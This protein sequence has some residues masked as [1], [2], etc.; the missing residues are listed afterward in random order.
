MVNPQGIEV[1]VIRSIAEEGGHK[2]TH[3]AIKDRNVFLIASAEGG[4]VKEVY[5]VN[6]I[7][8]APPPTPK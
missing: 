2:R 3:P 8:P 6:T 4:D 5:E 7:P 1:G